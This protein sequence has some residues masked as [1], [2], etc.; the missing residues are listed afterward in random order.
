MDLG[1]LLRLWRTTGRGAWLDMV[2]TTLDRMAAGGIYDHLGGGFARYSVD[3]R[4]LVP[5]FE[6][7]LYDNALLAGVYVEAY[8]AT[9]EQAYQR[10]ARE[11]LDYVLRDMTAPEG[12]FYSTEDADSAPQ[13]DPEG[14]NEEGLFYTW[15]PEEI[16]KILGE[17][18]RPT[19]SAACTT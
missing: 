10:I 14:H 16:R 9:G 1:V 3:E 7:M 5:H 15:K 11:T 19:R 4:W 18:Q 8:C 13:D 12:G 2:R 6:K 17:D